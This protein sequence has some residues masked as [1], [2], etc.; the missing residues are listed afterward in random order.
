MPGLSVQRRVN[1]RIY[2]LHHRVERLAIIKCL[3]GLLHQF[4]TCASLMILSGLVRLP[5]DLL[6]NKTWQLARACRR[7]RG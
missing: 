4:V 3:H 5:V 1:R 6:A 7:L 2:L